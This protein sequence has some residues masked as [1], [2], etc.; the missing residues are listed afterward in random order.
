MS[1]QR[2]RNGGVTGLVDIQGTPAFKLKTPKFRQQEG[3]QALVRTGR[4]DARRRIKQTAPGGTLLLYGEVRGDGF[5]EPST[6]KGC[7]GA[8]TLTYSGAR[9]TV[10]QVVV[11]EATVS[12]SHK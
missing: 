1:T 11:L 8:V 10:L 5:P 7:A 9:K 3:A 2:G 4:G 6:L 12:Y